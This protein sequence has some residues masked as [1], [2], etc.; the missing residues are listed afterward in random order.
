MVVFVWQSIKIMLTAIQ[1]I[2]LFYEYFNSKYFLTSWHFTDPNVCFFLSVAPSSVELKGPR[3]ARSGDVLSFECTTSN[4]NPPATIQWVVDNVTYASLHSR[5]TPSPL[6]GWVTHANVSVRVSEND[7]NKIITC[8]VINSE[9]NAIK[10]ESA[11][12][13][14][15]CKQ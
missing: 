8:N 2:Q 12:L 3:E 4:S 15:I 11:M 6:G 1:I 9:L 10:T 13:T 7:R 14:V 5:T